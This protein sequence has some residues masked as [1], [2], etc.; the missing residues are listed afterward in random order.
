MLT[1]IYENPDIYQIQVP[2]PDNPLKYLNSYVLPNADRPLIVDTGFNRPECW[3]ALTSGLS[4]LHVDLR[5]ADLFITHLHADHSGLAPDLVQMGCTVYMNPIDNDYFQDT[6]AGRVW[7]RM[8]KHFQAE[9]FPEKDIVNQ[10][11]ANQARLY[12]AR[13]PYPIVP[14]HDGERLTLAGHAFRAIT[15][16]G[17]T[18]GYTC[19][20]SETEQIM[21]LG[22]HVLFDI[23]P[24]ITCWLN[25]SDA[26]GA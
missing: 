16:P 1:Q 8:E 25:M 7:P 12:S 6:L 24:N 19:L 26:L 22:D 9:G 3:D 15:T 11:N 10:G 21:F 2:L 5:T 18:K 20:Y 13:I 23:T 4:Q 14:V 17:H